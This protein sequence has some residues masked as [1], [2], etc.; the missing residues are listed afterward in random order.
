MAFSDSI[1]YNK[2]RSMK[3]LPI[4][5]IVPWASDQSLIPRGWIVCNGATISIS[6]YPLLFD[7]IGNSYGGT[8]G[9]TFRLPPLTNTPKGIVDIFRGH[10]N[11]L[12]T[13]GD[14]YRPDYSTLTADTFW[15]IVANGDG[16]T[17]SSPQ[18]QW[19]STIDVVGSFNG[20]PSFIGS[21]D[22]MEI[23]DGN[24][25]D[26]TAYSEVRLGANHLQTHNHGVNVTE[27]PSYRINN[28]RAVRCPDGQW[29]DAGG[30]FC[31]VNCN[32]TAVRRVAGYDGQATGRV[33]IGN[34]ENDFNNAWNNAR[35][36]GGGFTRPGGGGTGGSAAVGE[37]AAAGSV[38][39]NGD[40]FCGGD[41]QCG[42]RTLFTSISNQERTLA[43]VAP[44]EHG[45]SNYN[46]VGRYNVIS[47]GLRTDISLNSVTLNNQPGQNFCTIEATT[48][49]AS[50]DMLY[51]I[52]AY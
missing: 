26:T 49:T 12:Q 8:A 25:T 7:I 42:T 48:A 31:R 50:L 38:Y 2:I 43:E 17:G 22:T 36:M 28:N 4:G 32:R 23:S 40:G 44:H 41:M 19:Q 13:R 16:N 39:I 51:I 34:N 27:V 14:A 35:N 6:S 37:T 30:S 18:T 3:G 29:A 46:F 21:Y 15:N 24:F 52:R 9:T 5:A 11:Y 10:F 47:P 1:K 20:S 45:T 33:M